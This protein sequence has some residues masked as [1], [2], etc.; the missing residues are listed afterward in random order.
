[1][2][3]MG[4]QAN[5][6][7][8]VPETSKIEILSETEEYVELAT[9]IVSGD[10]R[11]YY[12]YYTKEGYKD[13]YVYMTLVLDVVEFEH[14]C[15]SITLSEL[16]ELF[17]SKTELGTEFIV[18]VYSLTENAYIEVEIDSVIE[19]GR[20][21]VSYTKNV[22]EVEYTACVYLDLILDVDSEET[23]ENEPENAQAILEN[24]V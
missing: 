4:S 19:S 9:D 6:F 2:V 7:G 3:Y 21:R 12:Q 15:D 24:N 5:Q 11:L 10:Y 13:A 23:L 16:K 17:A 22:D 14:K 1:M 20:Y 8:L 18:E